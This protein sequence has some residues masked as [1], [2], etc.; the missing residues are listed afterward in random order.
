[1]ALYK[2]ICIYKI[3]IRLAIV[4]KIYNAKCNVNIYIHVHIYSYTCV[5]I[6]LKREKVFNN[7][8]KKCISSLFFFFWKCLFFSYKGIFVSL[9]FLFFLFLLF[10]LQSCYRTL[11]KHLIF[12]VIYENLTNSLRSI[13]NNEKKRQLVQTQALFPFHHLWIRQIFFFFFTFF[14]FSLREIFITSMY[15]FFTQLRKTND[16]C[17]N[18]SLGNLACADLPINFQKNVFSTL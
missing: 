9:F 4:L 15:K 8:N 2:Y 13:Y 7:N 14:L 18:Q 17:T 1:M 3:K 6:P 10:F 11:V 16:N 12:L 5:Q